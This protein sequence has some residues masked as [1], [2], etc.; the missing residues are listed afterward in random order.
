MA[1]TES[2]VQIDAEAACRTAAGGT[3]PRLAGHWELVALAAEGSWA[4]VYCARPAGSPPDSPAAYAVKTLRPDRQGDATALGLLA[5]EA[6]AGRSVSH[7]HLISILE[8]QLR[9]AP[10]LVVMP[11]LEGAT[12]A[13]RLAAGWGP[14]LPEALWIARQAAEALAAL[15]SAGWIHG[16]IKPSNLFVSPEGHVTLLDLGFARHRGDAPHRGATMLRM[17][18]GPAAG[19]CLIGTPYYLAPE[20]FSDS[21]G[22]DIRSDL[23][24]LGI[25]LYELLSGRLPFERQDLAG[26]ANQHKRTAP[27]RLGRLAPHLPLEVA[28]LVHE[29]LAKDPLRRP[30]APGEVVGRLVGLE[31]A[32]FT[33][34]V[35][36]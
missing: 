7:P 19:R 9:Q 10:P 14:D 8:V 35:A 11:W 5:R 16:D 28:R 12:L 23:Y 33:E 20:C 6:L 1:Q 4:Q 32:T 17:V 34:R 25:V 2:P 15:D 18:P 3:V 29:M 22:P 13:A 31:I 24:S 21:L 36:A 27:V 30:Q 26:L